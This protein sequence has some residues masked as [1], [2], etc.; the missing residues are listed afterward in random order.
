MADLARRLDRGEV[1]AVSLVEGYLERIEAIDRRGPA[2][3]SILEIDPNARAIAAA[4]DAERKAKGPR[5]PLHGVPIVVK[6]NIDTAGPMLTTAGSRALSEAPAPADATIV[7]KL[8]AAGAVILGKTNLSEWANIRSSKS[9]SGWSARGGLTKNPHAL[10]RNTSGSSSG[11]AAAIAAGLAAGSLGTE[12]DGS[13]VSPSSICGIVGLK[14]TVGLVSRAGIIPISASQ[15]T[16]GP[17]TRTVEDAAMLLSAIVGPDPRDK[18]TLID[19]RA[20]PSQKVD[21]LRA[22]QRDAAKG[23]RIGVVRNI[24][25]LH[26]KVVEAFNASVRDMASLGAVMIDVELLHLSEIDPPEMTVL[27]VELRDGMAQYLASRGPACPYKTLDDLVKYNRAHAAEELRYFGQ[28]LFEQALTKGPIDAP[29]YRDARALCLRLMREEGIDALLQQKKLDLLMAPTGGVAW[30]TDLVNGDAFTGSSSTPAAVAGYPS[31]TVPAGALF[32]L[33]I[34]VSFFA[35][36]YSEPLIL[37]VAYAYEQATKRRIKPTF[38][39]S[40]SL[41]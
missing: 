33:P 15:D 9:T 41:G 4:L 32:G 14:P 20:A 27:L 10:D 28:E 12:T 25:N 34:G 38:A 3:R 19:P 18:A 23:K 16:A 35:G 5:S 13:I 11:S 8:R 30:T 22:L 6:D 2:L 31:I 37:A 40:A 36:A 21:Y 29:A 1:T 7:Q 17:M 26:P 39:P 24:N